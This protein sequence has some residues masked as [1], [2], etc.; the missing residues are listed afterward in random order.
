MGDESVEEFGRRVG[1]AGK[2]FLAF[3]VA[4]LGIVKA[5]GALRSGLGDV[6]DFER[7]IVKVG[8]VSGRTLT[9]LAGLRK[10]IL[11]TSSSLGVDSAELAEAAVTL[12][13]T[14]NSLRQVREDLGAVAKARL[15]P[16]FGSSK[17]TVEA[18]I[19]VQQQFK[20]QT[21][22]SIE[23]L[24]K[25]NT[26]AASF[27]VESQDLVTAI[28]K[29]GGAFASAGG[30]LDEL[31]GLF[32]A[33]RGTSRETADTIGTAFRTITGRLAR[34][35][36][37]DFFKNE[38]DVKLTDIDGK[39]LSPLKAIRAI[40]DG[41]NKKGITPRDT[42]FSR[43]V[44]ELGGI[45]Q[46]AKVIPLLLE[47]DKA[48]RV[49][50]ASRAAGGSVARDAEIAQASLA[51]QMAKV[52]E[53]FRKFL[54]DVIRDPAFLNF[55]KTLFSMAKGVIKVAD[56]LKSLIPLA[57][58]LPGVIGGVTVGRL[59]TGAFGSAV[60]SVP[61]IK[62]LAGGGRIGT[63]NSLKDNTLG[64]GPNGP[65]G[66]RDGETVVTPD[67]RDRAGRIA[68]TS[69]SKLFAKAGIPGYA[70][71]GIIGRAT[72]NVG[73][74]LRE[75]SAGFAVAGVAGLAQLAQVSDVFQQIAGAIGSASL[76]ALGLNVAMQQS[77]KVLLEK[78]QLLEASSRLEINQQKLIPVQ[79][80]RLELIGKIQ[81]SR[82]I[83]NPA[84]TSQSATNSGIA[85]TIRESEALQKTFE[86]T[87]QKISGLKNDIS[88][89]EDFT[90]KK[91]AL[92]KSIELQQQKVKAETD[93]GR[94]GKE[95]K[96]RLTK[97]KSLSKRFGSTEVKDSIATRKLFQDEIALE[98]QKQKI[99]TKQLAI[100]KENLSG[101]KSQ[102]KSIDSVV[103]KE[104]ARLKLLKIQ[105]SEQRAVSRELSSQVALE[106]KAA[107]GAQ[108][109]LDN[110]NKVN[111]G[112]ILGTVLAQVAGGAVTNFA[113]EQLSKGNSSGVG[114]AGVG[115]GLSL[116]AQFAGVGLLF[117]PFGAA[118][119]A[120]TG[121]IV[122]F[123]T[124]ISN[125][126]KTLEDKRQND[127]RSIIE[128][129]KQGKLG[130]EAL[131]T[132]DL[133]ISQATETNKGNLNNIPIRGTKS[134][135]GGQPTAEQKQNRLDR[136]RVGRETSFNTLSALFKQEAANFDSY[137]EFKKALYLQIVSAARSQGEGRFAE[138]FK[139]IEEDVKPIIEA[140]AKTNVDI[141]QVQLRIF[142]DFSKIN[143]FIG[144]INEK[145]AG[146]DSIK[147]DV[148]FLTGGQ[149]N[150]ESFTSRFKNLDNIGPS[151]R[152]DLDVRASNV[153]GFFGE[154]GKDLAK[155]FSEVNA[156]VPQLKDFAIKVKNATQIDEIS[157]EKIK[158]DALKLDDVSD[159]ITDLLT[160]GLEKVYGKI[161]AGSVS[162]FDRD[163]SSD[164]DALLDIFK[165]ILGSIGQVNSVF[166]DQ[167]SDL[168]A[169]FDKSR[170]LQGQL[171]QSRLK[172]I[173]VR[174]A[175][176]SIVGGLTRQRSTSG[177][178]ERAGLIVGNKSPKQIVDDILKARQDARINNDEAKNASTKELRFKE[179]QAQ[180]RQ[181][182]KINELTSALDYL[183]DVAQRSAQ[184]QEAFRK[185]EQDREARKNVAEKLI[186]GTPEERR[187][188]SRQ[189]IT[190]NSLDFNEINVSDISRKRLAEVVDFLRGVGEAKV[191]GGR[192]SGIDLAN[193]LLGDKAVQDLVNTNQATPA[194]AR[195]FA[196]TTFGRGTEE[197]KQ[198]SIIE[199]LGKTA[200]EAVL[201]QIRLQEA[202]SRELAENI[203]KQFE[204]V[205]Q[206]FKA[207]VVN[208]RA[209]D[210]N[211][212]TKP[213]GKA[214]GGLIGSIRG[215]R[216]RKD[217]I[218]AMLSKGEV[219]LN[220]EQQDRLGKIFGMNP[221]TMFS[222]AGVPG[223]ADGGAVGKKSK[224]EMI[225]NYERQKRY[226]KKVQ[227]RKRLLDETQ[228]DILSLQQIGSLTPDDFNAE[229]SN[230]KPKPKTKVSE[231]ISPGSINRNPAKPP[232]I[233]SENAIHQKELLNYSKR[234]PTNTSLNR[235]A[236]SFNR[237]SQSKN[238]V[239]A[240]QNVEKSTYSF[241]RSSNIPKSDASRVSGGLSNNFG[242]PQV[243]NLGK[244]SVRARADQPDF[245]KPPT[246]KY[247]DYDKKTGGGSPIPG[248]NIDE[249]L[250]VL[251]ELLAESQ[252][253]SAATV[254]A[255]R[256]AAIASGDGKTA[257]DIGRSTL[258][259]LAD[260]ELASRG[261]FNKNKREI[262]EGAVPQV[263][264]GDARV[265]NLTPNMAKALKEAG[266]KLS[267]RNTAA[268]QGRVGNTSTDSVES[269]IERAQQKSKRLTTST[270][271]IA[272]GRFFNEPG[273]QRFKQQRTAPSGLG[274]VVN[275]ESGPK[276]KASD[277]APEKIVTGQINATTE[278]G[279]DSTFDKFKAALDDLS[280]T[281]KV[282]KEAK[283]AE[284]ASVNAAKKATDD[285]AVFVQQSKVDK[286]VRQTKGG[287]L[288]QELTDIRDDLGK[289]A[290]AQQFKKISSSGRVESAQALSAKNNKARGLGNGISRD[291]FAQDDARIK[292]RVLNKDSEFFN[293]KSQ[294][295]A[296]AKKFE[297]RQKR[298][299]VDELSR[300]IPRQLPKAPLSLREQAEEERKA[301][302]AER[303]A[304][305][306]SGA[307]STK[308]PT[309]VLP[310]KGETKAQAAQRRLDSKK[311][312]FGVG[313]AV[314]GRTDEQRLEDKQKF[315]G[316]QDSEIIRSRPLDRTQLDDLKLLTNQES[317]A[318]N[319]PSIQKDFTEENF[320]GIA[321][322][323]SQ[324][325]QLRE[326]QKRAEAIYGKQIVGSDGIDSGAARGNII[327]AHSSIQ[328]NPA[329]VKKVAEARKARLDK[330]EVIA[331]K[332]SDVEQPIFASKSPAAQKREE[333]IKA[334]QDARQSKKD[335]RLERIGGIRS[336][337]IQRGVSPKPTPISP[338]QTYLD[339]VKA[340]KEARLNSL[341]QAREKR[342]QS[343]K[344]SLFSMSGTPFITS[345]PT[346]VSPQ[347]TPANSAA[348]VGSESVSGASD[349]FSALF[350][351]LQE[352]ASNL[353]SGLST[354]TVVINAAQVQMDGQQGQ[355]EAV[356]RLAD[357]IS[358]FPDQIAID[359]N[360]TVSV[361]INGGAF[362]SEL[363][364]EITNIVMGQIREKMG[365]LISKLDLPGGNNLV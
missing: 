169:N 305:F 29:T 92:D 312:F 22:S 137:A 198:L 365:A 75:N 76:Q 4:T 210:I 296:S 126:K 332:F 287:G 101:L 120:A 13:Q 278:Q 60:G 86:V 286:E 91:I 93:A 139:K 38:I 206:D 166:E 7:E 44:E 224:G 8:Q 100:N 81:G 253:N 133:L 105:A 192:S 293:F 151:G 346:N 267:N 364:P 20:K 361:D 28:K 163:V 61:K 131:K 136:I 148:S 306:Q 124:S 345:D 275:Q 259:E 125:A 282:L 240:A 309:S 199:Q 31:L 69:G 197:N 266:E 155:Q 10:E 12:A 158:A 334:G 212:G 43:I 311:Q 209:G 23:V 262:F 356:A 2:R 97:L 353:F 256:Q 354:N 335:Q 283:E 244:G 98:E 127:I 36:T 349:G 63:K 109:R 64:I 30:D 331:K 304:S 116:A 303:V 39:I 211:S 99:I 140:N 145:I 229:M 201:Q 238:E 129:S 67:Q 200:Q 113:D 336:G 83:L 181:I 11:A 221:N 150:P 359:G 344:P 187:K 179:E 205:F 277:T 182:E 138:L 80:K 87:A 270:G 261:A 232:A 225:D 321:S 78:T 292:Q 246:I 251:K 247:G 90:A 326:Q 172:E 328:T 103:S 48:E 184:A 58:L 297:T 213:V 351:T 313:D 25:L 74:K 141:G 17:E 237:T 16:T 102:K 42:S 330:K 130:K 343:S 355:S 34:V 27:P 123:A 248:R 347:Q 230:R 357:A 164:V 260:K 153:G 41:I 190:S 239:I 215:G 273:T 350:K 362:F 68:G 227:E 146:L 89:V 183:S 269:I 196:D 171:L 217:D 110:T 241:N 159:E 318:K 84:R 135:P 157:F 128:E 272:R 18:L 302:V 117:G 254:E 317:L 180:S 290:A 323:Q 26:V 54:D 56:S 142:D 316:A 51:V 177:E 115:G 255:A 242:N 21:L 9:Q 280:A 308:L 245:V 220:G 24:D 57:V 170:Q 233:P 310:V 5:V 108:R 340:D 161:G 271:D 71:G 49:V 154:S 257:L 252:K 276:I 50:A 268:R 314:K 40:V 6:I 147:G 322:P 149:L 95:E 295:D 94:S 320:F 176:S 337:D 315:F 281:S 175:T 236:P 189:V 112:I 207:D 265:N 82:E 119:G 348:N 134:N 79:E 144:K 208:I 70:S 300:G 264:A 193:K 174:E 234:I 216:N 53:E 324:L 243:P 96:K 1:I 222:L 325:K 188:L 333:A 214:G 226:D 59:A 185:A 52:R 360:I 249:E 327:S 258:K 121:G 288:F 204:S 73:S 307:G 274:N 235:T 223:F 19:A 45:K 284:A 46:R 165:H 88:K 289:V 114:L 66:L 132:F 55:T 338:R 186:I 341:K 285:L 15:S 263:A 298:G 218:P 3:S 33:V 37:I 104:D 107:Q 342:L 178:A 32:T 72:A 14:G 167:V 299:V 191:P 47:I 35:K 231:L 339:Q 85:N 319:S 194:E 294:T 118:I 160:E 156:L 62:G 77:K 111:K 363:K 250:K 195:K 228:G 358:G 162:T 352:T 202:T 219:V 301:R 279:T 173:S 291:V 143:D 203:K 122:G 65:I 329:Q 168:R 152:A 106:Q